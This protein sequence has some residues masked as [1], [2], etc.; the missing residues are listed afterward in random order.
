MW[1]RGEEVGGWEEGGGVEKFYACQSDIGRRCEHVQYAQ[2][3]ECTAYV[4]RQSCD[5]APHASSSLCS[6]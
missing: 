2:Q 3:L 5:H 4:L 1:G 6:P